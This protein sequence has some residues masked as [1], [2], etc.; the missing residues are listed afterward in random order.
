MRVV[1]FEAID[2]RPR[3]MHDVRRMDIETSNPYVLI[4]GVMGVYS[5]ASEFALSCASG[6]IGTQGIVLGSR[7]ASL[8]CFEQ[9]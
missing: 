4:P 7:K 9:R 1:P 3:N 6:H 2:T 8:R 5:G